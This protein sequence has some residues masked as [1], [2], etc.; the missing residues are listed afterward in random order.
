M[1]NQDP[2][3]EWV[4]QFGLFGVIVADFV[5]LTVAGFGVGYL[6]WTKLGAPW[7][8]MI[9]TGLLGVGLAVY[10]LILLSKRLNSD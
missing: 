2:D 6:A 1:K 4:R 8:L 10:R 9:I 5:G 3:R 7:W